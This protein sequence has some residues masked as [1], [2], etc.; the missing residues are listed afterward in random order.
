MHSHGW[1]EKRQTQLGK[2]GGAG[3]KIS[4]DFIFILRG[5]GWDGHGGREM[6]SV[7]V[8]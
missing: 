7:V 1:L 8:S 5:W 2:G 4:W 6:K 3:P